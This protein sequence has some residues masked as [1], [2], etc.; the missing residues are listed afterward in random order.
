[1]ILVP[2]V[3]HHLVREYKPHRWGHLLRRHRV[4]FE[5]V[6]VFCKAIHFG[7]SLATT[8]EYVRG[9]LLNAQA[10]EVRSVEGLPFEWRF[11]FFF[12][13]FVVFI[14]LKK[15]SFRLQPRFRW[16]IHWIYLRHCSF[17]RLCFW[18]DK[19]LHDFM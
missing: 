9:D 19:D 5:P 8:N 11:I 10:H 7:E 15:K 14:F 18:N 13:V 1:M 6:F 4:R 3:G 12:D 17:A 2:L 16:S